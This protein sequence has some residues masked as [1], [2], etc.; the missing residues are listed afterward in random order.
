MWD[1]PYLESCCR[2]ALHRLALTG[3]G[4]RP[5]PAVHGLLDAPCL[6]RL[7]ARGFVERRADDRYAITDAG[8]ARHATEVLKRAG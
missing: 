8:R 7:Q 3:S 4:G 1:E 5:G 6:A 2:A